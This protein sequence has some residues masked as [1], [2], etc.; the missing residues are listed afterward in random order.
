V[1]S[2]IHGGLREW[3]TCA[4]SDFWHACSETLGETHPD[5]LGS[6]SNLAVLLSSQGKLSEAEPLYRDALRCWRETLGETHP[7]TLSSMNN[8][9]NL[10][11]QQGK[12]SDAE[13]LYR[14]VLRCRRETLGESH[15]DTL[16]SM[17]NLAV[18][19]KRRASWARQSRCTVRRCAAGERR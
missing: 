14:D 8:L 4:A 18:L 9:G 2:R 13:P 3:L 11:W 7:E 12:L 19:L 1:N 5:T 6:M 15:P 16:Q 10:L 17:N